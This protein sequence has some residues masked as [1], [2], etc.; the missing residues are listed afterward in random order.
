MPLQQPTFPYCSVTPFD[1]APLRAAA[2]AAHVDVLPV[3]LRRR[4]ML[5]TASV[6]VTLEAVTVFALN[7][8]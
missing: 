5:V 4:S 1:P 2:S 3:L 7:L 8:V 6:A